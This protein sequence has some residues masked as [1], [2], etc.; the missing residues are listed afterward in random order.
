MDNILEILEIPE[1]TKYWLVRAGKGEEYEDFKKTGIIGLRYDKLTLDE[2]N[3]IK[4]TPIKVQKYITYT[5]KNGKIIQRKRSEKAI[6]R[7]KENFY[8]TMYKSS[9]SK[10]YKL[11]KSAVAQI[12]SRIENFVQKMSIGDIIMVPYISS[13]KLLV[14]VITSDTYEITREEQQKL[15]EKAQREYELKLKNNPSLVR[16]H[17]VSISRKRRN[18]KWLNEVDKSKLS[19]NL[20]Y[21]ITMHQSVIDISEFGEYIDRLLTPIY[22]KNNKL[23]LLLKINSEKPVDSELWGKLFDIINSNKNKDEVVNIKTHVESPGWFELEQLFDNNKITAVS[24]LIASIFG[25]LDIKGIKIK[26]ALPFILERKKIK[27]EIR[28]MKIDNDYKEKNNEILLKINEEELNKKRLENAEKANE[29]KKIGIELEKPNYEK[30]E[31]QEKKQKDSD[32]LLD[33]E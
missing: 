33:E 21:T 6:M 23:H 16:K 2:I 19:P 28:G 14:G 13:R 27:E 7:D 31:N 22:I 11:S 3:S 18:V 32:D 9:I 26:G 8:K 5:N 4:N 17:S 25:N 30:N 10:H 15:E 20:F 29:L 12:A 24:L 1:K